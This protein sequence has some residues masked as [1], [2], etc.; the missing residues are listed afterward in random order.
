M[1][2]IEGEG[3]FYESV[4]MG[5]TYSFLRCIFLWV[6]LHPGIILRRLQ[7]AK[8]TTLLKSLENV[9]ETY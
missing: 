8:E 4:S 5:F 7:M 2:K 1:K 3:R 6:V 9:S